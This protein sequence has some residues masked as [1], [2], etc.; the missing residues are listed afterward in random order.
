[1]PPVKQLTPCVNADNPLPLDEALHLPG[2]FIFNNDLKIIAVDGRSHTEKLIIDLGTLNESR[3][4][5][6]MTPTG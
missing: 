1:M 3:F 6:G 4:V 5:A 2:T